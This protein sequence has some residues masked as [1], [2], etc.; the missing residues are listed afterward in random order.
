MP[1]TPH[2]YTTIENYVPPSYEY[3]GAFSLSAAI[4]GGCR[5]PYGTYV[6]IP[7]VT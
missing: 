6:N 7:G 4:R 3:F 1:D 5:N 2:S